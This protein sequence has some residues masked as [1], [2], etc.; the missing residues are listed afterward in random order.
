MENSIKPAELIQKSV[1]ARYFRFR[2]I[3]IT[4]IYVV[5]VVLIALV[6]LL[7]T[8]DSMAS[9]YTDIMAVSIAINS[10]M[11]LPL[12]FYYFGTLIHLTRHTENYRFYDVL[13]N[14]P[15]SDMRRS[16]YFAVEIQDENGDTVCINTNTVFRIDSIWEQP[17]EEYINKTAQIAYDKTNNRIVVIQINTKQENTQQYLSTHKE[18]TL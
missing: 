12:I 4:S 3:V 9:T 18:E 10:F 16:F 6:C 14:K 7:N 8:D 2:A 1:D 15:Y 13:L 17:I 5:A 11:C